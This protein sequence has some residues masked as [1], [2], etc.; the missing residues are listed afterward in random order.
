MLRELRLARAG[1]DS[2]CLDEP[3]I[4]ELERHLEFQGKL[5]FYNNLGF[6]WLLSLAFF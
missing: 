2:E 5:H 1:F 4:G 6:E 3:R